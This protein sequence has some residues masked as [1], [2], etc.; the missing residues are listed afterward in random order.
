MTTTSLHSGSMAFLMTGLGISSM[1]DRFA[2][3]HVQYRLTTDD[4]VFSILTWAFTYSL[5][6]VVAFGVLGIVNVFIFFTFKSFHQ[7]PG[8]SLMSGLRS[9]PDFDIP[10][11]W[12]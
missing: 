2:E 1:H 5:R 10:C 6:I 7:T 11:N 12:W 3:N 4:S 9:H 8:L